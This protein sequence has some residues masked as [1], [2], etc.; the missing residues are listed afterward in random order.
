LFSEE[1]EKEQTPGDLVRVALGQTPDGA[2]SADRLDATLAEIRDGQLGPWPPKTAWVGDWMTKGREATEGLEGEA[3][4]KAIES[5]LE[6]VTGALGKETKS[7]LLSR[8]LDEMAW[9][10]W[11]S[12]AESGARDLLTL[13]DR[14]SNDDEVMRRVSRARI[15]G[16]FSSFLAELRVAEIS[17]FGSPESDNQS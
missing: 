12:E 1:L 14:V 10:R 6:Q 11:Q 17:A 13:S 16:L 4:A 5:W 15:E 3:R 7:E 2:D 9:I 8:H